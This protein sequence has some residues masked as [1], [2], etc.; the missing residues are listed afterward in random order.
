MT[1]AGTPEMSGEGRVWEARGGKEP[2]HF[3]LFSMITLLILSALYKTHL[4]ESDRD[5][6][7]GNAAAW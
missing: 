3:L 4:V 6:C 1:R 5:A 7:G 2:A